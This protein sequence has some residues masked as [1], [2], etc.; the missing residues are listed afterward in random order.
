MEH[1]CAIGI[2]ATN[3][4]WQPKNTNTDAG[5]EVRPFLRQTSHLSAQQFDF[6]TTCNDFRWFYGVMNN[7]G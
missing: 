2:K 4:P 7:S 6:L 3:V 5:G 1:R